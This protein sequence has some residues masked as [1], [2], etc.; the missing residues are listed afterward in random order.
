M[1]LAESTEAAGPRAAP[2]APRRSV[3]SGW[4]GVGSAAVSVLRPRDVDALCESVAALGSRPGRGSPGAIA[5]GMGR[6]Y[7]DAAQRRGGL[8]V[9]TTALDAFELDPANGIVH[10]HA[11][12]TLGRLL[13]A[14][15]PAG[16]VLP[17]VPGTQHIS[18]G[19]AI[20][21]D[22][23]GKSHGTVGAFGAHVRALGLLTAAGELRELTRERDPELLAATIGGMGLTGVIVWASIALRRL[24]SPV[25]LVDSDRVERLDDALALLSGPGGEYRVAWLDLLGPVPARG[26]VTRARHAD[27]PGL[28]GAMTVSARLTVPARL[29]EGVLRPALVRAHNTY[30]FH[31]SPR[32]AR[33]VPDSYGAHMFPLDGLRAWPRLYGRSGLVQYQFAVPRGREGVLDRVISAVRSSPVPC[34]LAVLKD[35]GEAGD[36]PLSFPLA[37]WTLALDM[38]GG[39][40][41]LAGLLDRCDE[42]VAGAGGRVYLAKDG[43]LRPDVLAAMYPRVAE[44][45]AIRDRH[46]PDGVWASDLGART[47][48]VEDRR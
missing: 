31:R 43:R 34:Y 2:T 26:I 11:G 44:W 20:A 38:P 18:V 39:A 29:P 28:S 46:D 45:R 10:A 27:G 35:F 40:P 23:H 47:G 5:R 21:A 13:A 22:I 36:A 1:P 7:G 32:R 9:D 42:W 16:W 14:L 6:S 37:G 25:L 19:G 4:G 3:V 24:A 8:V 33:A 30:R 41:G 12:V 48:L 17:V 15:A